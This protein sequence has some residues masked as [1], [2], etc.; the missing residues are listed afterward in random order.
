MDYL[1]LKILMTPLIIITSTVVAR[2]WGENIGG[3]I[4]GLPMTSGP[5]SIFFALE[6]GRS[7]AAHAAKSAILGL[8]AVSVFCAA[9]VWSAKR[10][11]W[12]LSAVIGI[13]LYL[14]AVWAVSF[15]SPGLEITV[16]LVPTV[17]LLALNW[18]GKTDS[19]STRP[20]A[21]W[22]DLPLRIV[23]A[24]ALLV[25]ITGGASGLG[26][27][28]SGLLSPFPIF[29]FVMATFSHRQ[30]GGAAAWRLIRGVLT[31]LFSY[32][33]FF[34]VVAL[35]VERAA[36]PLVYALATVTALGLNSLSLAAVLWR[37]RNERARMPGLPAGGK[38]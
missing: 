34:V 1:L 37:R 25:L 28:W 18:I 23:I 7:F 27:T 8:I 19:L 24:T 6:Q 21:P 14:A 17:L 13:G 32:V 36:L 12:Q 38:G 33:A 26:S 29:T 10:F 20:T 16:F 4:V 30:G 3:L 35:L 9:Y 11:S 22:W 31:G 15:I 2:K 5:V